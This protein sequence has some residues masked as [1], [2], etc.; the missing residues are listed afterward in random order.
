MHD[1][2]GV[3]LSVALPWVAGALAA[4]AL[5]RGR[6]DGRGAICIGY[7][8]VVGALVTTFLMRIMSLVGWRWSFG[9]IAGALVILG[10]AAAYAAKPLPIVRAAYA[11]SVAGR[12]AMPATSRS[13]FWL[14][15][16]ISSINVVALVSCVAWGLLQ[17]YDALAQWADKAKVWYEYGRIVPFVDAAEWRRLADVQHFWD[18]NPRYPAT[19]PLLQVWTALGAGGW[20]ESLASM[21]W[22]A[23]FVAL[24]F[25]FYGQVRR[26]GIGAAKAMVCTYLLLS[27]P[28]LQINVAVSGMADLFVSVSYGLAAIGLW[29]WSKTRQRQDAA[30]AV[31]MAIFCATAKLEGIV[32]AL[33]LVPAAAVAVHRR[34]GLALCIAA[35]G[36]LL[37]FLAFG[38]SEIRILGYP[39]RMK[40]VDV[41]STIV[42]HTL[43]MDNW[44]LFWY[45]VV[46]IVGWNARRL[47]NPGLAPM[48]A[49]MAAGAG[50]VVIVYCFSGAAA[51]VAQE[52]LVN[53][54][55][56]QTVPA[57]AFYLVAILRE[58]EQSMAAVT[59]RMTAA[60][61]AA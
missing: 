1:V 39:V 7:G 46:A 11:R 31:L 18:A 20:D 19:V 55:L 14:L 4:A 48:T 36:A 17:P 45:A 38:P 59:S 61:S 47:L 37:L 10:A 56:L 53:R 57:L 44:H 26:L 25:A 42:E 29:Q 15:V 33:T 54:F 3:G 2:L 5:W 21:P 49:T 9:A 24:G 22:A 12:A 27:I 23:A 41:E 52:N 43:V 60:D 34:I 35:A 13:I 58:R 8:Y 30:L 28:L 50:F 6:A 40:L 32:W 51:G 16:A